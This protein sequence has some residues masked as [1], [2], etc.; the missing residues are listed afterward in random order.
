MVSADERSVAAELYLTVDQVRDLRSAGMTVGAH[1]D[2]HVRLSTLSRDEQAR[3]IDGALRVL[4][5]VDAP[6]QHFAYCYANG[7]YNADTIELLRGRQCSIALTTRPDVAHIGRDS[8][9]TLPRIDT[10]DL[11]PGGSARPDG[12]A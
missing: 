3:E 6:R 5:A 8:L 1:G 7:D 2:R 12:S 10:N 4:D 9:L 11:P